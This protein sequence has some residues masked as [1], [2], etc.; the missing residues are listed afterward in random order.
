LWGYSLLENNS[1]HSAKSLAT[2]LS[3]IA[4]IFKVQ[5]A[6]GQPKILVVSVG[7]VET[8]DSKAVKCIEFTRMFG[9][10]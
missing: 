2:L 7:F 5:V 3:I 1:K 9:D 4:F 6:R 10:T 8:F